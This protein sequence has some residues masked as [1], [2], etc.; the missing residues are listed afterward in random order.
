MVKDYGILPPRLSPS[1]SNSAADSDLVSVRAGNIRLS[2]KDKHWS[3]AEKK[4]GRSKEAAL[5]DSLFLP[6]F[7]DYRQNDWSAFHFLIEE[8]T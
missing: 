3:V 2:C 4:V 6:Y 5:W 7:H 1:N 8:I